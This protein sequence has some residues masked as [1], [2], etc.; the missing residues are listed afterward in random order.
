MVKFKILHEV[1]KCIGCGACAAVGP[2]YWYMDGD[3]SHIH[4]GT[5]REE[6]HTE[7][8]EGES[9]EG[10]EINKEAAEV[11]P[12]DCIHV[13]LVNGEKKEEKKDE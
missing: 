8:L 10:Y 6:D 9:K 3:K 5:K 12:V 1:E 13:D 4:K 7:H 2:D 11:C